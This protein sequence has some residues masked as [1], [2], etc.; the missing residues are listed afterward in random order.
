MP[1]ED[2]EQ[3]QIIAPSITS[4]DSTIPPTDLKRIRITETMELSYLQ[5]GPHENGIG[6]L[7]NERS[8]TESVSRDE[9]SWRS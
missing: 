1:G 6:G 7:R 3:I 9:V 2:S 4:Q 5:C 8:D